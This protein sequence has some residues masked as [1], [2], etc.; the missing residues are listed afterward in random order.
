M[1]WSTGLLAGPPAIAEREVVGRVIT[2]WDSGDCSGSTVNWSDNLVDAWYDAITTG[3]GASNWEAGG[4]YTNGDIGDSDFADSNLTTFGED[5]TDDNL[6]AADAIMACLHGSE[7]DPDLR[8]FGRVRVDDGGDANCNAAQEHIYLDADAEF[9]VLVSCHSMCD[10]NRTDWRSSF[11]HAHQIDGFHGSAFS[12]S[13]LV[14]D[15]EDFGDDAFEMPIA[16]AW[17]EELYKKD[18][19]F[20]CTDRVF[21]ICVDWTWDD[22]CPVG[23]AAGVDVDDARDHRDEEE[24]DNVMSH[25]NMD[26]PRL[27]WIYMDGCNPKSDPAQD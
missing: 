26:S 24:Y 12:G 15:Y 23:L 18:Y 3:H 8:W 13:S 10:D 22:Q 27:A 2:T 14:D 16:T 7:Y 25:P 9:V 1:S 4:F 20:R 17:I 21:G 19:S 6:D 5:D 11:Y